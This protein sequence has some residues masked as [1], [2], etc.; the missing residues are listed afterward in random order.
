[1]HTA[2]EQVTDMFSIKYLQLDQ[3]VN[4]F[5]INVGGLNS[6][7]PHCV[8]NLYTCTNTFGAVLRTL[9]AACMFLSVCGQ[10]LSL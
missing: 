10:V 8:C 1:M 4:C 6:Y 2:S 7:S 9:T 5:C 3:N